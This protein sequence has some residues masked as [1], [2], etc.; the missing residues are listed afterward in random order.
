VI[1]AGFGGKAILAS[2]AGTAIGGDVIVEDRGFA[3]E[4]SVLNAHINV[5]PGA[6]DEQT[7]F[8]LR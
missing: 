3:D 2:R 4:V 1:A 6:I 5:L 7:H 8:V